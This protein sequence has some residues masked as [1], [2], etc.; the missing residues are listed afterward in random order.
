M[1]LGVGVSLGGAFTIPSLK[2]TVCY[3]IKRRAWRG[4]PICYEVRAI[5]KAQ[6]WCT[7]DSSIEHRSSQPLERF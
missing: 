6:N 3:E 7:Q 2:F 4:L 5:Y 1:V